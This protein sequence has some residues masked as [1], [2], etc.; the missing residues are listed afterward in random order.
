MLKPT[1]PSPRLFIYRPPRLLFFPSRHRWEVQLN[2]AKWKT[3]IVKLPYR[4]LLRRE[5]A[6]P[7][8][9]GVTNYCFGRW[10]GA[11]IGSFSVHVRGGRGMWEEFGRLE[12]EVGEGGSG[13]ER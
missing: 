4:A 5:A 3:D 2:R 1:I 8:L 10:E 6:T 9:F 7:C 12:G 11:V 13:G